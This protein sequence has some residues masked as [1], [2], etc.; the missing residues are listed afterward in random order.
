MFQPLLEQD[1]TIMNHRKAEN[2]ARPSQGSAL[3]ASFLPSPFYFL[4]WFALVPLL[5][6]SRK[7]N[8]SAPP[9]DLPQD[10]RTP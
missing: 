10:W 9:A 7:H 3:T 4:A 6:E 1:P 2:P 8:S 5:E